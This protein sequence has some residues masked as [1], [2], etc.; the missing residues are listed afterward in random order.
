[1]IF[2][3]ILVTSTMAGN[4][5]Y[6]SPEGKIVSS[7]EYREEC[8]KKADDIAALKK[9]LARSDIRKSA[10]Y[11]N[12][13]KSRQYDLYS[14]QPKRPN[15]QSERRK[16]YSRLVDEDLENERLQRK[17]RKR[18]KMRVGLESNSGDNRLINRGITIPRDGEC[19]WHLVEIYDYDSEQI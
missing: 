4:V 15:Y 19:P 8:E 10:G 18:H 5:T 1:M 2:T 16:Y 13:K 9:I 11:N 14:G 3:F 12:S 6:Y 17:G 7:S